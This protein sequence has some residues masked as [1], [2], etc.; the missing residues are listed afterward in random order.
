MTLVARFEAYAADFEETYAN[1]CWSR[2]EQ[3]FT[4]DAIYSTPANGG[5]VSG[6]DAVL[7]VL[8]GAVSAFDRR[9]DSRVL[10]TT[11]GPHE[12]GN[13]VRRQWAATYRLHGAPDLQIGGSERAVF[14]GARIELLEVTFT[15]EMLARLMAYAASYVLPRQK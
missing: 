4:E 14:R 3:H 1:D 7:A 11:D 10:V 6:R 12:D 8:Q 5:R 13:E 9:C 2:L 15:P